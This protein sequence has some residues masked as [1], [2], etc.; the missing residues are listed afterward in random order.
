MKKKINLT[1]DINAANEV[2]EQQEK[3]MREYINEHQYEGKTN[4]EL[5]RE[6]ILKQDGFVPSEKDVQ[7]YKE[8]ILGN[9]GCVRNTSNLNLDKKNIKK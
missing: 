7:E 1:I 5:S 9:K 4:E 6:F 8:K 2:R 3:N